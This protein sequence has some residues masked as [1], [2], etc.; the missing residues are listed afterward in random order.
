VA[1]GAALERRFG[2]NPIEGSNP[3]PSAMKSVRPLW[4]G[5]FHAGDLNPSGDSR[6]F[7]A[8]RTRAGVYSEHAEAEKDEVRYPS[9]ER[10]R[11]WRSAARSPAT[12]RAGLAKGQ[13]R[14]HLPVI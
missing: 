3:S 10:E 7:G 12:K 13:G 4:S 6:G 11:Q 14:I 9:L 1:Y 8:A 5:I 2:S